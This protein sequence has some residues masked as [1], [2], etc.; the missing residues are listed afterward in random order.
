M[1]LLGSLL[2]ELHRLEDASTP[3]PASQAPDRPGSYKVRTRGESEVWHRA[4]VTADSITLEIAEERLT[5]FLYLLTRDSLAWGEASRV[6]REVGEGGD[7][8]VTYTS[9]GAERMS[10]S[11]ARELLGVDL[12]N[13]DRLTSEATDEPASQAPDRPGCAEDLDALIGEMERHGPSC[14]FSNSHYYATVLKRLRAIAGGPCTRGAPSEPWELRQHPN[15]SEWY[16]EQ[17]VNGHGGETTHAWASPID[18]VAEA[19]ERWGCTRGASDA[20]E[21]PATKRAKDKEKLRLAKNARMMLQRDFA[22]GGGGHIV[23]DA[24]VAAARYKAVKAEADRLRAELATARELY[25]NAKDILC[26]GFGLS[27]EG[28]HLV[29]KALCAVARYEK[30]G[31]ELATLRKGVEA[32]LKSE[33]KGKGAGD[34]PVERLCELRIRIRDLLGGDQ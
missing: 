34:L 27:D 29:D 26:S 16:C 30:Q 25:D 14:A 20:G 31:A 7:G 10:R 5:C 18:A 13:R 33:S 12:A 23:D 17:Q 22:I 9:K 28:G 21:V 24:L 4:E 8:P 1:E 3:E 19:R 32:A 15:G 11:F 2:D 6:L